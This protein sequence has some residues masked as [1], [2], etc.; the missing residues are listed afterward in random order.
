MLLQIHMQTVP[1]D[2]IL[3]V[4]HVYKIKTVNLSELETTQN[5]EITY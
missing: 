4:I 2:V 5:C 3:Y 1:P